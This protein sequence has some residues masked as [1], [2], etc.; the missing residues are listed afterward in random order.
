VS[1]RLPEAVEE[2][3][4][5]LALKP[6]DLAALT[7]LALAYSQLGQPTQAIATAEKAIESG[8]STGQEAAAE[9]LEEW[10]K[11]YRAEL[12]RNGARLPMP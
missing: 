12:Q 10:L 6:N 8:R 9:Q 2:L 7:N 5:A 3:Q 1:H 11:H 4:A